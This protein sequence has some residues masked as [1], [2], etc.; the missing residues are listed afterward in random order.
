MGSATRL[1]LPLG[2][3]TREA[4]VRV[5]GE[6]FAGG[7]EPSNDASRLEGYRAVIAPRLGSFDHD[8]RGFDYRGFTARFD[9]SVRVALL[10]AGGKVLFEK[11]Y[12]SGRI[13][14]PTRERESG[15]T[16]VDRAAY[17]AIQ[18]LMLQAAADV[19]AHLEDPPR[20]PGDRAALDIAP[21]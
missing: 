7:A 5:F 6:L 11:T 2:E 19:K 13:E 14:A 10:D 3:V 15:G 8:Y 17:V 9:V 12:D 21:P 16:A 18:R 20:G 4:A 1:E